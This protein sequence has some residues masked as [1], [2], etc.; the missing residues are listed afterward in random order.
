VRRPHHRHRDDGPER[1]EDDE[2]ACGAEGGQTGDRSI[3]SAQPENG[4]QAQMRNIP[5][6]P[7]VSDDMSRVHGWT[8][9]V[10]IVSAAA[11][12]ASATGATAAPLA[13]APNARPA[14]AT[15]SSRGGL[16][17]FRLDGARL[18]VTLKRRM[19]P[20]GSTAR[21]WVTVI[22]GDAPAGAAATRS[23]SPLSISFAVK[24][25][26]DLPVAGGARTIR[27]QF[28]TDVAR[29]SNVCGISWRGRNGSGVAIATMRLRRGMAPGCAAPPG[30]NVMGESDQVLV[31][32]AI[33]RND[34]SSSGAYAAC[35]K[36]TRS[37]RPLETSWSSHYNDGR[38]ASR[39][40]TEGSWVAWAV[41]VVT[42][43]QTSTCTV[44]R[45]NLATNAVP[46]EYQVSPSAGF[47]TSSLVVGKNGAI[48]WSVDDSMYRQS[49]G[50][51]IEQVNTLAADG[52]VV[53]LDAGPRGSLTDLAISPDG[54]TVTWRN[55]GV[56][57]SAVF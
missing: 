41:Q 46:Q 57:R 32:G 3:E 35:Y 26:R 39:F 16:A 36:P 48:A 37:W 50:Q 7:H 42:L 27:A 30:A 51:P 10:A 19:A 9:T 34:Y 49:P 25:R 53:T 52:S 40:S 21:P 14:L 24:A 23:R 18:V 6:P 5:P 12:A 2:G 44:Q 4:L 31:L 29:W 17:T 33:D 43:S 45:I 47:C 13:S 1:D 8:A 38:Y 11:L 22:C 54:K 55:G 28:G 15:G 56:A 20:R